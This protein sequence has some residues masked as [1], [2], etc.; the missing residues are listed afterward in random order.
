MWIKSV[1]PAAATGELK[2]LYDRIG[3]AR[4]GVPEIHQAQSLNPRVLGA[5]FAALRAAGLSDRAILDAILT[6]AYF[7]YA[8]RLVVALG[9]TIEPSFEAT[10]RPDLNDSVRDN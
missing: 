9:L 6:V 1:P 2:A 3:W 7:S 4:G 5:H 10:C 8:N